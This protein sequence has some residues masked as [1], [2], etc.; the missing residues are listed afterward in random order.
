M[1]E[2]SQ[3]AEQIVG[4]ARTEAERLEAEAKSKTDKLEQEARTRAQN[5]DSEAEAKRRRAARRHGAEKRR[6]DTEV[7]DL[8]G[9]ERE[10]RSRL[11]SYFT[12]QLEALDGSG[13]GGRL[14]NTGDQ[15]RPSG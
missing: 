4:E 13:E 7:E 14:P 6:L 9:F 15:R 12:E 5:L 11:K 1:T 2:A 3:E 10:Y 8:R